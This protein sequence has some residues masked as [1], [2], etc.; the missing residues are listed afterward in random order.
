MD[1]ETARHIASLRGEL[2]SLRASLGA[3]TPDEAILVIRA[4]R[5]EVARLRAEVATLLAQPVQLAPADQG[6]ATDTITVTRS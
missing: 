2:A 3:R 5:A 4:L 1:T 6:S